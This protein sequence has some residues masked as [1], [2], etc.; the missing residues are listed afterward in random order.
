MKMRN[1]K[2]QLGEQ[3][4]VFPF[5][6][7]LVVIGVGIVAGMLLYFG[8]GYDFR[9]IDAEVLNYRIRECLMDGKLDLNSLSGEEIK[10]Q[11]F[12]KCGMNKKVLGEKRFVIEI[13]R[14]SDGKVI[15]EFGSS[16]NCL[17]NVKENRAFPICKEGEVDINGE[18]YEIMTGSNQEK[19]GR[20]VGI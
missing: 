7:F 16:E 17:L 13:K 18:R 8:E 9:S 15:Y 19:I 11:I 5:F 4:L 12:E 14:A 2:G 10:N 3:I 20:R 6:F 1:R